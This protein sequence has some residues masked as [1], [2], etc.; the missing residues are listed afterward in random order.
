MTSERDSETIGRLKSEFR[1]L[2][3]SA[4]Q[5]CEGYSF[6]DLSG[7]QPQV[8][9]ID[10]AVFAQEPPSFRSAAFGVVTG[11]GNSGADL[12]A[13]NKYLGAPQIFEVR[14]DLLKR[15][16]ISSEGPPSHL[17]SVHVGNLAK[18]FSAYRDRWTP[19]AIL[20]AKVLR[21][22]AAQLDFLDLG[23]LPLLDHEVR[24]KLDRLLADVVR[25]GVESMGRRRTLTLRA[26]A[27]LYRLTFRLLAAKIL[28]DRGRPGFSVSADPD[29]A[30][31]AVEEF[32][33]GSMHRGPVLGPWATRQAVWDR[34][35]TTFHFQ[36]LSLDALALVYENTFVTAG[37][38]TE[39]GIHSTPSAIA[40]YVVDRL[41]FES[42]EEAER[43]VFEP[44]CGQS[45]LL[46]S[47]MQR[48][49]DIM[50]GDVT[51]EQRH[52]YLV[53]MLSG[54]EIDD[55]A[56]EVALLSLLLADY[57]N[58]DGWRL[59]D[60]DAFECSE[61]D[62][63]LARASIVLCNP[64][65]ERLGSTARR[66]Y[67]NTSFA[68]KPAEVLS[69]VLANPPAMLG[70]ILPRAFL[71]GKNYRPLRA[72][73]LSAYS[74]VEVVMLPDRVFKHSQ[75]ETILLTAWNDADSEPTLRL[76]RV[77]AAAV[78]EFYDRGE[79][80]FDE[81]TADDSRVLDSDWLPLRL[82]EVWAHLSSHE[83]MGELADL[84]RGIQFN[85]G[86]R[87]N[88]DLL[89]SEVPRPGFVRGLRS[90][91]DSLEP[92]R[93]KN[94]VYLN[95]DD[96]LQLTKAIDLPWDADKAVVN[97]A[98]GSRSAWPLSAALDTGGLVCYQN[99]Y[100]VWPQSHLPAAVIAAILNGV[101]ANAFVDDFEGKRDVRKGTVGRL[102]VPHLSSDTLA[103]LTALVAELPGSHA[104]DAPES[105]SAHEEG[106]TRGPLETLIDGVVLRAY[107]LPAE[108]EA[109]LLGLFEGT[110]RGDAIVDF[111]S[112]LSRAAG[113]LDTSRAEFAHD[114]EED[115]VFGWKE[116]VSCAVYGHGVAAVEHLRQLWRSGLLSD[117]MAA[118]ALREIGY[119]DHSESRSSRRALLGLAIRASSADIRRGAAEGMAELDDESL[120]PV[121]SDALRGE[122]NE[123]VAVAIRDAIRGSRPRRSGL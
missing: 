117:E 2:G 24:E 82:R 119:V 35:R 106:R 88:E 90:V 40:R 13:A 68:Y 112:S 23:L 78:A 100:G 72:E 45:V 77:G 61:F 81:L 92:N 104:E 11:N 111:C 73:M 16:K 79:V 60:G 53:A 59:I 32:Y 39:L 74:T 83:T 64:P 105:A 76:A 116:Q 46:I 17:D 75:A 58:A 121:L 27:G 91:A 1:S 66:R 29:D 20:D 7:D 122:T 49:R 70:F 6:A 9:T 65:F 30:V 94:A 25:I 42:V 115:D 10:L 55:F 14:G 118:H 34:I 36:N 47:A 43:R 19:R 89:V 86:L 71:D 63:E 4:P 102:P 26:A 37:A 67:G 96:N 12:V 56:R 110:E 21:R 22:E 51:P 109:R 52:A 85:I 18:L 38:R 95:A 87:D 57:P 120:G 48:L 15:W 41:P 44:F 3:Y 50:R 107:E 28:A 101:V 114:C 103:W 5:I 123:L 108:L 31:S 113:V 80:A 33:F 97:K 62:E 54:I 93:I 8:R 99:F 98:R 69:R 84:R